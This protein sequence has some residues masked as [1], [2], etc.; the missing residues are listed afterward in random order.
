MGVARIT[1][2]VLLASL[3]AGCGG[4]AGTAAPGSSAGSTPA[5]GASEAATQGGGAAGRVD[6]SLLAPSDFTNAGITGAS[7]PSDNPDGSSHYCVYAGR[8]G[9]TGGIEFD[10]FLDD[11]VDNAKATYET[12]IG[13]G[14]AG[15]APAGATFD[16]SSFGAADGYAV[17]GVRQGLLSFALSAPDSPAAQAALVALAALVVTRAGAAASP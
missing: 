10:V 8:S 17:L 5:R 9:A 7:A 1:P 16:Q 15:P 12:M 11:S 4:A 3:L 6:C 13:E 2:I 14:P